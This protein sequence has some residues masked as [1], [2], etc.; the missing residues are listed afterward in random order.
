LIPFSHKRTHGRFCMQWILLFLCSEEEEEFAFTVPLQSSW[1]PVSPIG[2]TPHALQ[3]HCSL[4]QSATGGLSGWLEEFK[5][6][7]EPTKDFLQL[8]S[9]L[10]GS[11]NPSC[12]N[13]WTLL[14]LCPG[15]NAS[16]LGRPQLHMS[17]MCAG[18]SWL[19]PPQTF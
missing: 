17:A 19:Q 13:C 5:A 15:W 9:C 10:A 12:V 14:S 3:G 1:G 6:S 18:G 4:L 11:R 8:F 7:R 16:K 2:K